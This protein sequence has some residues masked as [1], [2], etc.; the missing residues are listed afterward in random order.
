M[1]VVTRNKIFEKKKMI[2]KQFLDIRTFRGKTWQ[3]CQNCI[4][5]ARRNFL[6]QN[7]FSIA[8]QFIYWICCYLAKAPRDY[9]EIFG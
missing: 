1:I 8:E 7:F 6:K 3:G 5:R 2:V 9:G 4:R